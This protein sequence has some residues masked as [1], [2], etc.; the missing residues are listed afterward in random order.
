MPYFLSR[1]DFLTIAIKCYEK[2][3]IKVF[4]SSPILLGFLLLAICLAQ[5]CSCLGK[6]EI[7]VRTLTIFH[8]DTRK[9][10]SNFFFMN[11]VSVKENNLLTSFSHHTF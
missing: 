2:S 7:S 3:D 6:Y 9:F 1:R 11:E 10:V 4:C 5:A 8:R